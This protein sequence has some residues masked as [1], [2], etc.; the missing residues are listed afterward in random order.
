[1]DCYKDSDDI[2]A[3]NL[4]DKLVIFDAEDYDKV[5]YCIFWHLHTCK[6]INNILYYAKFNI[7]Q[8]QYH[9]EG[10]LI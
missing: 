5:S 10:T 2:I 4:G 1:M 8:E 9:M 6:K 7:I 3:I